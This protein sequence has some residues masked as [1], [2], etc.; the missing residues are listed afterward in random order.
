MLD[1]LWWKSDKSVR[2]KILATVLLFRV[3]NFVFANLRFFRE[4]G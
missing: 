4:V 3:Y 1:V 2:G